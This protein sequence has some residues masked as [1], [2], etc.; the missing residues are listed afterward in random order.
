MYSADVDISAL[1]C[2]L[3]TWPRLLLD[4]FAFLIFP[5]ENSPNLTLILFYM[6]QTDGDDHLGELIRN[7]PLCPML[8][9]S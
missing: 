8:M 2:A 1:K 5:F 3:I 4:S 9:A 6:V 7:A